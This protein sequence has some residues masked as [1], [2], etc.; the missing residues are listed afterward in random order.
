M[1]MMR[2]RILVAALA[3][4]ATLPTAIPHSS[5]AAPR[6]QELQA[7]EDRLHELEKEFE[8][9]VERYNLVA[10][11]LEEIQI[12]IATKRVEIGR[13]ERRMNVRQ[14]AAD[15]AATELYMGGSTSSVE[16]FL[17]AST[18]A[19]AET[20]LLYLEE[21]EDVQ[22]QA[23]ESLELVRSHLDQRVVELEEAQTRA[24]AAEERLSG[25]RVEIEAK[26]AEQKDEIER[27]NRRIEAAQKR[28]EAAEEEARLAA[29]AAARAAARQDAATA[30]SGAG[31]VK[32]PPPPNGNSAGATA[33]RAALSQLG[34]PYVWA[35]E[36]PDSYDCSGLTLW[37]WAHAG[38][39]LP[40]NSGM[41]YATTKRVAQG[42]LALGDLLF[43]GSPIHHVGM[44]I[45]DGKMVEAPYT[46]SVVRINSAFR[47]DYVGAGRPGV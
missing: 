15:D 29:L 19:D 43:F 34:K 36:G 32:A 6:R 45:G 13:I 21:S 18:L 20:R 25:L 33:V 38:V 14:E 41:Q 8:L 1:R 30:Q 27:L 4:A 46:G 22:L 35:A 37:A 28:R 10:E 3:L 7:A 26:L 11:R 16:A 2:G 9:V 47:D 24:R 17:G 12:E 40:H 23:F 31:N 42:D 5:V 44:Y 39:S